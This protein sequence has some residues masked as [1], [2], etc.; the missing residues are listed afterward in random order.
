MER[1]ALLMALPRIRVAISSLCAEVIDDD[2][3]AEFVLMGHE[4]VGSFAL[5]SDKTALLAVALGEFVDHADLA[6]ALG[7]MRARVSQLMNLLLLA[8]DIQEEILFLEAPPR[9]PGPTEHSLRCVVATLDW[10]EQRRRFQRSHRL[11]TAVL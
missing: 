5:S 2:M 8:P 3:L 4:N 10:D 6:R 1:T 9:T 7:F 11:A